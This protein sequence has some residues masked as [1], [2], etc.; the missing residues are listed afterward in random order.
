V[1]A[2][3]AGRA[4]AVR[5]GTGWTLFDTG[6]IAVA[7]SATF[8]LRPLHILLSRPYWFDESWPA[9]LSRAPWS[10]LIGLSSSAPVG[11]IALVKLMPGSSDQRGRLVAIAFVAVSVATTYALTRSLEWTSRA[12]ARAAA[13][14]AALVVMLAPATLRRNDLKQYTADAACAL[15]LLAVGTAVDRN[16]TRKWLAALVAVA[17]VAIA[18]SLT[19]LFVAVAVFGGLVLSAALDRAW[20]WTV[21]IVAAGAA[22][23]L[24]MGA[25]LAAV[26]LPHLNTA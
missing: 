5:S 10:K 24:L 4:H 22:V 11:F 14:V 26:V 13:A 16:R 18:F 1:K 17:V 19:A 3:D 23:A 25:Y 2:G 6:V 20:R 15:L 8:A 21:E 12:S 7:V 9:A